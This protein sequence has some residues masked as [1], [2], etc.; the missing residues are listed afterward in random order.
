MKQVDIMESIVNGI[1]KQIFD[2]WKHEG[3]IGGWSSEQINCEIDSKEYVI[4]LYEV[5][6]GEHW[7]EK[8]GKEDESEI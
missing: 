4:R 5:H 3:F 7:S 1:E 8:S 6:N 2:E